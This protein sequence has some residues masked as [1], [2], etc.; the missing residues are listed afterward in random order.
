[1]KYVACFWAFINIEGV[2]TLTEKLTREGK[3]AQRRGRFVDCPVNIYKKVTLNRKRSAERSHSSEGGGVAYHSVI[4]HWSR[5]HT[6][7]EGII[8]KFIEE[9]YRGDPARGIVV[10]E[11]VA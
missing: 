7:A 3:K 1:M 4:G 2:A 10:K 5:Y 11:C 8:W 6:K 9:Y